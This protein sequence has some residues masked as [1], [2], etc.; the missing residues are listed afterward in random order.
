[1]TVFW[2]QATPLKSITANL[3]RAV[4]E[5][6]LF[7]VTKHLITR[8]E[9]FH[10]AWNGRGRNEAGEQSVKHQNKEFL[11]LIDITIAEAERVRAEIASSEPLPSL[12][13]TADYTLSNLANLKKFVLA[14]TLP[15]PSRGQI[16]NLASLN[17]SRGIGK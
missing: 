15:R 12:L 1:M 7:L 11:Q 16:S 9:T 2:K 6:G 13:V 4:K 10:R 8:T 14:D 3:C 5:A 17:I